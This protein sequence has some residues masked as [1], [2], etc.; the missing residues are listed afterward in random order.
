VLAGLLAVGAWACSD[1]TG[2]GA[3]PYCAERPDTAVVEFPDANLDLA[4]RANLG[5]SSLA[6]LT[7]GMVEGITNLNA[8]SRGIV[9]IE[10]IENLTG[11]TILQLRANEITDI[12]P[13]R[14]LIGLA[15]LNL[16]ANSIQDVEA[17]RG[18]TQLTFLAINENRLIVAIDALSRLTNLTGTLWLHSNAI[19]DLEPLRG[20]TG[21]SILRAYDNAITDLSP[22]SALDGLTELH[23]HINSLRDTGGLAALEALTA[24][25]LHSNPE[26]TDI[27][28]LI[29]NPGLGPGTDVNLVGTSVSCADVGALAAKGVA[30]ISSCP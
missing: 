17:L 29:D 1:P 16:A 15:S 22:L 28:D 30:V 5:V 23:V 12:G 21:I 20:L 11:L 24:V 27:Q 2:P 18:L 9:S 25:S 10:G 6:E 7:C 3:A 4:I 26:L 8:A 19:R 14:G 13:L